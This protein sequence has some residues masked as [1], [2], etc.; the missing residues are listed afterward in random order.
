[1]SESPSAKRYE[2]LQIDLNNNNDSRS[3]IIELTGKNKHVLEVGTSTGYVTKILRERGN[4]VIGI[5]ID[6]DAAKMARQYC[7]SII[8]GDVEELDF[9]AYIEPASMDVILLAD[10]LEHLR[11]PGRILDKAKK[12]LKPNGYLVVSLPNV[13][14]GDLILNLLNGDFRYTSQGLL[15]ETHLRFFGRRNIGDIFNR[16]GYEIKDIH[17]T[18]IPVGATELKL[19]LDRIPQELLKIIRALPDSDVYQFVFKA[20]PSVIPS[21][22]LI[23][24]VD[25]NKIISL[26]KEDILKEQKAKEIALS[27]QLLQ[28]NARIATLSQEIDNMQKSIVWQMTTRFHEGFIERALPQGSKRRSCYDRGLKGGRMLANGGLRTFKQK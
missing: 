9:D 21:N 18:R 11:W 12:Y 22:E 24:A 7:K 15:D 3:L 6:K 28:A 1:M 20:V 14:H 5:E 17:I 13:S 8:V 4:S 26:C 10:V 25:F 27:R 23:P 19:D 2:P 16:G